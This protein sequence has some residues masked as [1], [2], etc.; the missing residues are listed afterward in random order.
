MKVY[1]DQPAPSKLGIILIALRCQWDK[2]IN[3]NYLL[4]VY[5]VPSSGQVSK[6]Q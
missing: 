3:L 5:Y 4:S 1:S 2:V 6:I